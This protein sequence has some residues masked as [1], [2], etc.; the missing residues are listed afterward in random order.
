MSTNLA[1]DDRLIVEAQK[2]GG[3]KSKKEAV[4]R[5][6]SEYISH[7]KQQRILEVFGKMDWDAKYDYKA[8]RKRP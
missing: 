4:T 5:A 8:W 6:L 7:H 1:I 2:L 3:H